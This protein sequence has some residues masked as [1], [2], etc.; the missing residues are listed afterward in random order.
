MDHNPILWQKEGKPGNFK[1]WRINEDLLN[2]RE[3]V[4]QIKTDIKSYF[5][6]NTTPE[7]SHQHFGMHSRQ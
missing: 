5:K 1:K 3:I 7:I 4:D 2:K 6:I